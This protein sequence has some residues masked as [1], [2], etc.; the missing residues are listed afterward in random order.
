MQG[1]HSSRGL[2]GDNRNLIE[3]AINSGYT[4]V[5]D[6][7]SFTNLNSYIN[8]YVL[9]LFADENM[10]RPYSPSLAE[11]TSMAIDILSQ[12]DNGYF[13]VLRAQ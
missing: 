8:Q 11:M 2:R 12:N 6:Q 4:F 7:Q 9:G 1:C 5:C 3:E 10:S 13:L